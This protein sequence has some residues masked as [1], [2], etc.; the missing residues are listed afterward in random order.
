[1]LSAPPSRRSVAIAVASLHFGV[2]KKPQRAPK[3]FLQRSVMAAGCRSQCRFGERPPE[4]VRQPLTLT[5]LRERHN[6]GPI[7]SDFRLML[8][9]SKKADYAL[10]AMKPLAADAPHGIA[11]AREI[12]ERYDIPLELLAKVLQQLTRHGLLASHMGIHGGYYLS[13]S[14]AVIS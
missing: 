5:I 11:S 8:R 10:M 6:I 7:R 14:T 3:R 13:R 2:V 9:L 12:A 1:R 4:R